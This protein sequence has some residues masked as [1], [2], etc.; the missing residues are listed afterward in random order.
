ML[1]KGT[2]GTA[3]SADAGSRRSSPPWLAWGEERGS[4]L[5]GDSRHTLPKT[6]RRILPGRNGFI[7]ERMRYC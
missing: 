1:G 6:E 3:A 7:A 2:A 4:N 5:P